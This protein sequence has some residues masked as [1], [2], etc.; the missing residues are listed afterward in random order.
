MEKKKSASR[1]FPICEDNNSQPGTQQSVAVHVAELHV[2]FEA[3]KTSTLLAAAHP[4]KLVHVSAFVFYSV[5]NALRRA[6]Y[7]KHT[8]NY[9]HQH[10]QNLK[11]MSNI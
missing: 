4:V 10:F 6:T 8:K 11:Y 2:L 3:P 1:W 7:H 5:N 9:H